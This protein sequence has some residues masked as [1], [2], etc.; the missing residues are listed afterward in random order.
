MS[1]NIREHRNSELKNTFH[2]VN[3]SWTIAENEII[4]ALWQYKVNNIL[5]IEILKCTLPT[6]TRIREMNFHELLLI[7][8]STKL[9]F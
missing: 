7:F 2:I 3:A 5:S 4:T 6:F 8:F 9:Q 1:H